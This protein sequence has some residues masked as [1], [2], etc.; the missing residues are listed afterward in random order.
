MVPPQIRTEVR[1]RTVFRW[2]A[3]PVASISLAGCGLG[4]A[5]RENTAGIGRS[6]EAIQTNTAAVRD[7]SASLGGLGTAL[8]SVTALEQPLQRVAG[9]EPALRD[10]GGLGEPLRDLNALRPALEE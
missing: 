1:V 5:I 8:T 9:L 10:V 4:M 7:S 6:T 3:L 2:M